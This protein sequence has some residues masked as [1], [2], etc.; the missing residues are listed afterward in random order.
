[1][2][3]PLLPFVWMDADLYVLTTDLLYVFRRKTA[4]PA[5]P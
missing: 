4:C 5:G 2:A 3:F 1:M